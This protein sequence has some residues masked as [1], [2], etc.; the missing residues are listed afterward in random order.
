MPEQAQT[1]ENTQTLQ[2][3]ETT[4]SAQQTPVSES[5]ASEN[6]SNQVTIDAAEHAQ[7][8]RMANGYQ[9]S[10]GILRALSG[11]GIK[12]PEQIAELQKV[13][14]FQQS[15]T[16]KGISVDAM[17]SVFAG[18]PNLPEDTSGPKYATVDDVRNV[19]TTHSAETH[20]QSLMQAEQAQIAKLTND[21]VG[22]TDDPNTRMIVELVVQ[23]QV[24][25]AEKNSLYPVDHPLATSAYAPLDE[26]KIAQIAEESKKIL[27]A[28]K[29]A[30]LVS[31]AR[32]A[33]AAMAS[34]A[35][36]NGLQS[37]ASET[38]GGKPRKMTRD[39]QVAYLR[40]LNEQSAATAGS[41]T[42]QT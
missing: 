13:Q 6:T 33:Q 35:G 10:S 37:P 29:G 40:S 22:S 21:L 11:A 16:E 23:K 31:Q 28:V 27:S 19:L 4:A 38:D 41:A 36:V 3:G 20:H 26:A 32:A 1:V 9:T 18:E 42:I 2:P 30:G 15:L 17:Q 34:P 25:E 7:L 5:V 12:S 39:E 8:Q 24:Q 14:S